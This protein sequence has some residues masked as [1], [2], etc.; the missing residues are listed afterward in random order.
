MQLYRAELRCSEPVGLGFSCDEV[1]TQVFTHMGE[2]LT[3]EHTQR[4]INEQGVKC[5]KCLR[6]NW[7]IKDL[8]P[9]SYKSKYPATRT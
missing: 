2:P 4:V 5:W 9:I 3:I 7:R 6:K 8:I 1:D